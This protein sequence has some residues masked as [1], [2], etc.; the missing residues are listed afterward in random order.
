MIVFI[1]FITG[2]VIINGLVKPR[3]HIISKLIPTVI[4]V[5]D[6][7]PMPWDVIGEL[8]TQGYVYNQD[9]DDEKLDSNGDIIGVT[10]HFIKNGKPYIYKW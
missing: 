10:F 7:E 9:L 8:K 2:K 4:G 6:C 1:S 3:R 5:D